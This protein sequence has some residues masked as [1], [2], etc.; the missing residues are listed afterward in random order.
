MAQ[1]RM[2]GG[3]R[4]V[5]HGEAECCRVDV[6]AERS[7]E[8]RG[9]ERPAGAGAAAKAVN[10]FSQRDAKRLF[11]QT[12][13]PDVAAKLERLRA[14]RPA[15]AIVAI[16][17]A[18]LGEN[19]EHGGERQHVVDERW[20]AEEAR[21]RRDLRLGAHHAALALE[22]L[23]HGR[24]FTADIG[25]ATSPNRDIKGVSRTAHARAE[26][27]ALPHQRDGPPHHLDRQR[28]LGADIDEP[29]AGAGREAGDDH[30][31]DERE[32]IALHQ[33]PVGESAAV[34]LVGIAADV[35]LPW[36]LIGHGFPFDGRRKRC[37]T[38]ATQPR[39]LDLRNDGFARHRQRPPQPGKPAEPL[40]G[41]EIHG[42]LQPDAGK[43]QP[44]LAAEEW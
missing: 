23:Q 29:L 35:F 17:G 16:G 22:A 3:K 36:R 12:A 10:Q 25:A 40:I 43:G 26:P 21:D 44:V 6:A 41:R 1:H 31:F 18:A 7:A 15:G 9:P 4:L 8:L 39:N 37:P 30:A 14:P 42:I 19:K 33:H 34:A 24:L 2:M 11:D 32:R 27:A 28:I 38:P 5:V 13:L 20:F